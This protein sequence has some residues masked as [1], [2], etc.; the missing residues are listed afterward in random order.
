VTSY[1]HK[2]ENN[3]FLVKKWNV[4]PPTLYSDDWEKAE[5]ELVT[6]PNTKGLT[7]IFYLPKY[8]VCVTS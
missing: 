3:K 5:V 1:G 2:D 7:N 8:V 4:E 6:I